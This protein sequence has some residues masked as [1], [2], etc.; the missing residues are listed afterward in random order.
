MKTI[1]ASY[2]YKAEWLQLRLSLWPEVSK[3]VHEKE[4]EQMLSSTE[5]FVV[6]FSIESDKDIL[7]FLEASIREIIDE[8]CVFKKIGYIEGWYVKPKH[9]NKGIGCSLAIAA[10]KWMLDQGLKEIGSDTDI[11]NIISQKAHHSLGYRE[12]DRLILYRKNIKG[13]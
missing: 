3:E 1:K 7:G 6:F 4:I 5:R 10:E 8:G 13:V 11:E 9:R 2:Q 12:V